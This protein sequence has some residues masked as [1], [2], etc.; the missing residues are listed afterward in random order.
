MNTKDRKMTGVELDLVTV[1]LLERL[2]EV[3]HRNRRQLITVSLWEFAAAH[4]P[5]LVEE[6]RLANK[7]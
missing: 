6:V 5:N 4:H 1:R 2:V 7:A 3:D